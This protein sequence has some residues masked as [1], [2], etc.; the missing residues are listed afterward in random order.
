[1]GTLKTGAGVLDDAGIDYTF[2]Y[3]LDPSFPNLSNVFCTPFFASAYIPGPKDTEQLNFSGTYCEPPVNRLVGG[4][5]LVY[6]SKG[7]NGFGTVS[8][9]PNNLNFAGFVCGQECPVC[10]E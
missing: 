7:Y 3:G 4:Y 2:D 8:G 6:S 10:C 1:V 5:V 9:T